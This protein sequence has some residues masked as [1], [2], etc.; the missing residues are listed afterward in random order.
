M[1]RRDRGSGRVLRAAPVAR[2]GGVTWVGCLVGECKHVIHRLTARPAGGLTE[3]ARGSG[4]GGPVGD[5]HCNIIPVMIN[6]SHPYYIALALQSAPNRKYPDISDWIRYNIQNSITSHG[7]HST[8]SGNVS[9]QLPTIYWYDIF[10]TPIMVEQE[11]QTC[12]AC[13]NT[14]CQ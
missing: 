14:Q 9:N 6:I 11:P 10:P 2:V 1:A 13:Y 4:G 5:N 3:Q 7:Q 8:T 12:L